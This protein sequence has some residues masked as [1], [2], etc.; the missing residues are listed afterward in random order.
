MSGFH[1]LTQKLKSKNH[2]AYTVAQKYQ[3]EITVQK[4]G[5]KWHVNF[6]YLELTGK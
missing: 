2:L 3:Y 1:S 4:R 5:I 6:L